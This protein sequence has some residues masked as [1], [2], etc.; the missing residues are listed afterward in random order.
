MQTIQVVLDDSLLKATDVAAG[1][2]KVNRSDLIRQALTGHLRRLQVAD[3][4]ERD[5]R[6]YQAKPQKHEEVIAWETAA[7]WPDE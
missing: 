2:K 7:V 5:R 6:G 4:E 3:L 1:K